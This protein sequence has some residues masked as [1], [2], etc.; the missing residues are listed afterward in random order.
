MKPCV[1]V[2]KRRVVSSLQE[3][4]FFHNTGFFQHLHPLAGLKLRPS[5]GQVELQRNT[6]Q[7]SDCITNSRAPHLKTRPTWN[8]HSYWDASAECI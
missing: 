4:E 6:A 5:A 2:W 3:R 7:R 1:E 8:M